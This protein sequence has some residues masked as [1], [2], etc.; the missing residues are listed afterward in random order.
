MYSKT[1]NSL[2]VNN[3]IMDSF[4]CNIGVKQGDNISPTL[5]N[6][7]LND[8][9][10]SETICHP[11]NLETLQV[12]VTHLLWADDLVILSETPD[13]LQ[14]ALNELAVY[15]K[16]WHI[17]VNVNKSNVMVTQKGT[18]HLNGKFY[19]NGKELE[20]TNEYKYL[21]C[22]INSKEILR[23]LRMIYSP[24]SQSLI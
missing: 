21:G 9:S 24:K 22:I 3:Q 18:K 5:F 10:F 2:E 17:N 23:K 13:G 12:H 20:I 7:F 19:L 6:I 14:K 4:V 11:P 8:L 16:N 15:C 1:L